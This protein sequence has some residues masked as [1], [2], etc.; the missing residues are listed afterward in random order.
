MIFKQAR[1]TILFVLLATTSCAPLAAADFD[2]DFF[3]SRSN[4]RTT[5]ATSRGIVDRLKKAKRRVGAWLE[6]RSDLIFTAIFISTVAYIIH[7]VNKQPAIRQGAHQIRNP[8]RANNVGQAVRGESFIPDTS[9]SRQLADEF[10]RYGRLRR[11][12]VPF[13]AQ[14]PVAPVVPA[15]NPPAGTL[16]Q[17]FARHRANSDPGPVIP[18]TDQ[19]RQRALAVQQRATDTLRLQAADALRLQTQATAAHNN[20]AD[21]QVGNVD[22]ECPICTEELPVQNRTFFTCAHWICNGCMQQYHPLECPTCRTG[23]PV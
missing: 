6:K 14:L 4:A 13:G 22:H 7:R 16:Q 8:Q 21:P 15:N 18:L 19:E 5:Q 3:R 17:F 1:N 11:A 9:R 2:T 12:P 23:E 20:A 10:L